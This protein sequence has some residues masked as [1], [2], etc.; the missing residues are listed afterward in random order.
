LALFEVKDF[1]PSLTFLA[2]AEGKAFFSEEKK[3]KTFGL[4]NRTNR[5]R[6]RPGI[7]IYM[8]LT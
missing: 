4:L 8:N 7:W 2:A 3:Q 5:R 6:R 1:I